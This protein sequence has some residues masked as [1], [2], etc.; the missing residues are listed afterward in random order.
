MENKKEAAGGKSSRFYMNVNKGLVQTGGRYDTPEEVMAVLDPADD[1]QFAE[2]FE[3]MP[4][5]KEIKYTKEE[6]IKKYGGFC[7]V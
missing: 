7:S 1:Y 6:F 2:I 4:D 5:N 3:R